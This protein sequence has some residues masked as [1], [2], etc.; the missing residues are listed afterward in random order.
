[1]DEKRQLIADYF[2]LSCWPRNEA[3]RIVMPAPDNL[4]ARAAKLIAV[5][6]YP[7]DREL[8]VG[9]AAHHFFNAMMAQM[10]RAAKASQRIDQLPTWVSD[11]KTQQMRNRIRSGS[12]RLHFRLMSYLTI[13]DAETISVEHDHLADNI[14]PGFTVRQSEDFRSV[15]ISL[16]IPLETISNEWKDEQRRSPERRQ[17]EEF[18]SAEPGFLSPSL[19]A[20]ILRHRKPFHASS[21][22]ADTVYTNIYNRHVRPT[23]P[24]VHIMS[25]LHDA[26]RAA[27]KPGEREVRDIIPR[28]LLNPHWA[29]SAPDKIAD[30][31]AMAVRGLRGL[32][33]PFC[34]CRLVDIS[35]ARRC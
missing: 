21:G 30:R 25:V 20:A 7:K 22:D 3:R 33:I 31:S 35:Q 28:L 15:N 24:V 34:E 12:Y 8:D 14:I 27:T 5:A 6:A 23:F 4:V 13:L 29:E 11:I 2:S 32:G 18:P 19:K 16:R 1:V 26:M 17:T 10:F 9:G